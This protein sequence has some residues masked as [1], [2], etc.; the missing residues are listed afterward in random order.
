[1][2]NADTLLGAVAEAAELAGQV[3]LRHFRTSL[4]VDT[5]TDGSPVTAADR[6]AEQAI[7]DWVERHFPSDGILGEELG[8][9]RPGAARRWIVDPIDGTQTFIRGVPLWG[10]LVA[11]PAAL[12]LLSVARPR[13]QN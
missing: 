4:T 3:A 12:A 2:P 6:A 1:M 5:K 11:V 10:T 9:V 7:H 8:T 13:R